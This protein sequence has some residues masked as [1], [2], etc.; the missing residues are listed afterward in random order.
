MNNTKLITTTKEA[1]TTNI[2]FSCNPPAV[3]AGLKPKLTWQEQIEA[4]NEAYAKATPAERRIIITKDALAQIKAKQV[5]VQRGTYLNLS[6]EPLYNAF[7]KGWKFFQRFSRNKNKPAV[8]RQDECVA[9]AKGTLFLSAMRCGA[10]IDV[11]NQSASNGFA[12]W[13]ADNWHLIETAFETSATDLKARKANYAIRES[14][15]TKALCF[16]ASYEDS[17]DRL[18]AILNN[19]IDNNGLFVPP[20]P[21]L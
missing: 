3:F 2:G 8:Q 13:P 12:D 21:K 11:N 9:C 5:Y 1:T 16:G 6:T 20:T 7:N 19:I 10:D 15:T 17:E 18:V 14:N 4:D